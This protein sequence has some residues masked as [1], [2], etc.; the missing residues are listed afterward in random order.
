MV[1][2]LRVGDGQSGHHYFSPDGR[3]AVTTRHTI[4]VWDAAGDACL[5]ENFVR[6]MYHFPPLS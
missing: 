3:F 1:R 4:Y 6:R 5:V 2:D